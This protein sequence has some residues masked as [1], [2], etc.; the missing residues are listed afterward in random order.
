MTDAVRNFTAED[1]EHYKAIKAATEPL[2]LVLHN[3]GYSHEEDRLEAR[4]G[5]WI[6]TRN[7][8]DLGFVADDTGELTAMVV[9]GAVRF[10][11]VSNHADQGDGIQC[12]P[13][14]DVEPL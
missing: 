12:T 1:N 5:R 14:K 3:I 6:V 9:A 13:F 10:Y 8:R 2:G 4:F 11:F 7:N